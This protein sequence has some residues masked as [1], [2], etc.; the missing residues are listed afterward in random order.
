MKYDLIIVGMGIAGISAAIYAKN[1]GLNV[2]MIERD[3][4]GGLINKINI[5][6]N[7]P[8]MGEIKGPDLSYRLFEAVNRLNIPYKILDVKNIR[9]KN[10]KKF[11]E[12]DKEIFEAKKIIIAT[13]RKSRTLGLEY[14]SELLGHGISNCALCD[15]ALYKNKII[16]IVGG[17]NSAIEEAIY[18]SNIVKKIYLIHRNNNF[19]ADKSLVEELNKKKNVEY[20]FNSEVTFLIKKGD[21]LVGIEINKQNK[22]N[23]EGLFVYIGFEPNIDFIKDLD[24]TDKNGYIKVNKNYETKISGIYAVGDAIKKDVYQLITAA[25]DGAVAAVNISKKI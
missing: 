3:I 4:P 25:N 1:S 16:A 11:I 9:V 18:L 7:Y 10:N 22:L 2:L 24:I 21:N 12:T 19:K 20:Y 6:N 5:I 8:G 23:I 15:G 17:G 13:G 14:E